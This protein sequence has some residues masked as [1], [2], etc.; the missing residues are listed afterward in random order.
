M[1]LIE[2]RPARPHGVRRS[3][4]RPARA[5]ARPEPVVDPERARRGHERRAGDARRS[6]DG[7]WAYTLY[8]GTEHPFVHA[9]DTDRRTAVCIDLDDLTRAWGCGAR[10]AR[11]AARRGGRRGGC[12]RGS[13]RDAPRDRR[14]RE[15]AAER[16]A[17]ATAGTLRGCRSP[18]PPPRCSCWRRVRPATD[19]TRTPPHVSLGQSKDD[20]QARLRRR[21]VTGRRA[22]TQF[23]GETLGLRPRRARPDRLLGGRDVSRHLE[24]ERFGMEFA[25]QKNAHLALHVDD[26]AAARAELGSRRA[27]ASPGDILDTG[28]CPWRSSPT[29]DG[30]D[31]MLHH[32]YAPLRVSAIPLRLPACACRRVQLPHRDG[33]SRPAAGGRECAGRAAEMSW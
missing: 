32:R 33:S 4:L 2:Y 30:N 21:A 29:R 28:V 10:A 22:R 24:P 31:L 12:S 13:T 11:R 17:E 26:V 1:Y 8:D 9:L 25:P 7:R 18:R 3:R 20:H 16:S 27:S 23:Y 6:T 15:R 19:R 5:A 14:S